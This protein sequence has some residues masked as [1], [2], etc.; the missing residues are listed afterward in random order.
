M[1]THNPFFIYQTPS[2]NCVLPV[3]YQG[4][5]DFLFVFP[6]LLFS[7]E[8]TLSQVLWRGRRETQP[9]LRKIRTS[10]ARRLMEIEFIYSVIYQSE[11]DRGSTLLPYTIPASCMYYRALEMC[12]AKIQSK[13]KTHTIFQSLSIKKYYK[14]PYSFL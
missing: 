12:L 5:S 9:T 4:E 6:A 8:R 11:S 3:G 13:C 1:K 10:F 14:I 2:T 7:T